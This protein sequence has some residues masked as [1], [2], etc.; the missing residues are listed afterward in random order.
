MTWRI[1]AGKRMDTRHRFIWQICQMRRET[2]NL[3]ADPRERTQTGILGY[4]TNMTRFGN[5]FVKLGRL[6]QPKGHS[7]QAKKNPINPVNPV[8]KQENINES[9]HY[10]IHY[11]L[12]SICT[13][14]L[15][16]Q[17]VVVDY[18]RLIPSFRIRPRKVLGLRSRIR[19][20]PSLPSIFQRVSSS[21]RKIYSRSTCS[22]PTHRFFASSSTW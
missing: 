1:S 8:E 2:D 15:P 14:F 20:A 12:I 11:F 5:T 9:I 7:P 13:I 6:V 18:G 4:R 3:T 16:R 19:A 21:T 10:I 22:S 17:L